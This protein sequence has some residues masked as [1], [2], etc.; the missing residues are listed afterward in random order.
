MPTHRSEPKK[1]SAVRLER[2]ALMH[3]EHARELERRVVRR[4]RADP[5]TIEDA[6]SHAWLQ[7][8]THRSV[9]LGPPAWGELGW[10]TQTATREAWRLAARQVCDG[11]LDPDTIHSERRLRGPVVPGAD[12]LADQHACL[13]LVAQMP[14]RPR[15]FS[16]AAGARL[17]LPGD[18]KCCHVAGVFATATVQGFHAAAPW[19]DPGAASSP[20]CGCPTVDEGMPATLVRGY[21]GSY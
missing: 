17:Q 6:C 21:A 18:R 16:L 14:P 7:L 8:L 10:L 13:Q 4:A 9:D 1:T 20:D 12:E 5:Q 3:A 15:R 19:D 2:I 11:L